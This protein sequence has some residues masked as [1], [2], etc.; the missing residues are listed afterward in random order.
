MQDHSTSRQQF[1]ATCWCGCGQPTLLAI[2]TRRGVGRGEPHRFLPGHAP[3]GT[4]HHAWAGD[5]RPHML[6]Y[7]YRRVV[8]HPSADRFGWI[9][10]HRLVLEEKIGRPLTSEDI[11]HHI[12]GNKTNNHPDNLTVLDRAQHARLHSTAPQWSRNYLCC[13]RCGSTSKKH[14]AHGL[15]SS[16]HMKQRT[17]D[18]KSRP[19]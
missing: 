13:V 4:D 9:L 15:C 3:R 5:T 2:T 17:L 7:I 14:Q 18:A 10:E 12:D 1:V 16:C 11:C 19:R 8:G 6:G